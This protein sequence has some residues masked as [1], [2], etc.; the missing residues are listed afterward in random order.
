MKKKHTKKGSDFLNLISALSIL[1]RM[2][3]PRHNSLIVRLYCYG[4][5]SSQSYKLELAF[6]NPFLANFPI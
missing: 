3:I 5:P 2:M 4:P 1:S 6:V